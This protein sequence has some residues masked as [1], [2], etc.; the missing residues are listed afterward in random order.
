MQ[1]ETKNQKETHSMKTNTNSEAKANI[2]QGGSV[3]IVA[4]DALAIARHLG[5]V[6]QGTDQFRFTLGGYDKAIEQSMMDLARSRD[7]EAYT[8]QSEIQINKGIIRF[9]S[10]NAMPSFNEDAMSTGTVIIS[11]ERGPEENEGADSDEEVQL[12]T[13]VA[14]EVKEGAIITDA[15]VYDRVVETGPGGYFAIGSLFMQPARLGIYSATVVY[16]FSDEDMDETDTDYLPFDVD[17]F[18]RVEVGAAL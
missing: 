12:A 5:E 17:H 13:E 2:L 8:E 6:T 10:E 15:R 4:G 18:V 16:D 3:A 9:F 1:I 11:Y 7:D 14:I